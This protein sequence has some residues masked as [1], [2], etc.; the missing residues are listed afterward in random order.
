MIMLSVSNAIPDQTATEDVAFTFTFDEIP[1]PMQM[2]MFL[3]M[4]PLGQV[5]LG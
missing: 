5:M 3:L 2:A 1:S 4:M